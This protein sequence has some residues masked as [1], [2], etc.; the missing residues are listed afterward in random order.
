MIKIGAEASF[1]LSS[2]PVMAGELSVYKTGAT[3]KLAGSFF[4]MTF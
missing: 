1:I 3:R 2:N 4:T